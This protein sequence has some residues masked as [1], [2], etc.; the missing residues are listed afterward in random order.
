LPS[1][2]VRND[3]DDEKVSV[4]MMSRSVMSS[5]LRFGTSMPTVDEPLMRSMRIVAEVHDL[6]VLHAGGRLEL[7]RGD[8]RA[9]VIRGDFAFDGELAAAVFDQMP[10]L[11]EL[12]V[13]L[14]VDRVLLR[15]LREE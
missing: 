3:G 11:Q 5:R 15:T 13:D 4:S 14:V 7:E 6:R 2:S 1:A 10:D 12:L 8:D 9:R